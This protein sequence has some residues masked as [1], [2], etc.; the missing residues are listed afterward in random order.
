[1]FY[2]NL[3]YT[4]SQR[5]TIP[6]IWDKWCLILCWAVYRT[7]SHGFGMRIEFTSDSGIVSGITDVNSRRD[8]L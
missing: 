5:V 8:E 6:D 2:V 1:M 7:A 4:I 3:V